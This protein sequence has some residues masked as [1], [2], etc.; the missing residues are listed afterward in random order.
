MAK[1]SKLTAKIKNEVKLDYLHLR[2]YFT[3][4]GHSSPKFSW[5]IRHSFRLQA[6]TEKH[7]ELSTWK[8]SALLSHVHITLSTSAPP[9][10][11]TTES[12]AK[13]ANFFHRGLSFY[14]IPMCQQEANS[15]NTAHRGSGIPEFQFEKGLE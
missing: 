8:C 13:S 7:A 5:S 9:A 15:V 14:Y 11:L 2:E 3:C 6:M 1:C 4:D 10:Q 12:C